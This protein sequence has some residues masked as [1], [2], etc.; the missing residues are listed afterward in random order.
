MAAVAGEEAAPSPII[1]NSD[2]WV[3]HLSHRQ[4]SAGSSPRVLGKR[5]V[6]NEGEAAAEEAV[7]LA[8]VGALLTVAVAAKTVL[9]P[10][11]RQT[12]VQEGQEGQ[13][14]GRHHP[15]DS[16]SQKVVVDGVMLA[17]SWKAEVVEE[18]VLHSMLFLV[19]RRAPGGAGV[20]AAAEVA[21]GSQGACLLSL[22]VMK[23]LAPLVA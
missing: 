6:G 1:R 4:C 2:G 3:P 11:G 17:A 5:G 13:L 9:V 20:S 22:A 15:L 14:G 7:L 18:G 10:L 16:S 8:E 12:G 21:S 23:P 19:G